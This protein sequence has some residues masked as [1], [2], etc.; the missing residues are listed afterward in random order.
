MENAVAYK[1]QNSKVES[2]VQRKKRA[3]MLTYDYYTGKIFNGYS[4]EKYSS[5]FAKSAIVFSASPCSIP[6]FTQ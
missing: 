5:A 2:T 1:K 6:S 4:L 3:S